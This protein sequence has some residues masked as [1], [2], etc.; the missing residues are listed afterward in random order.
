M[1]LQEA[2]ISKLQELAKKKGKLLLIEESTVSL[3]NKSLLV[4][5]KNFKQFSEFSDN[6]PDGCIAILRDVPVTKFTKNLNGRIYPKKLWEKVYNEGTAENTLSLADHP[7]DDGSITRI[8]G[9]WKNFR[10]RAEDAVADWYLIGKWGDI[11]LSVLK[12]GGKIGTS[13]VGFGEL[14]SDEATV[15]W[16]TYELVRLG[17]AVLEPSQGV[18]ATSKNLGIEPHEEL[19]N[20]DLYESTKKPILSSI[21]G[22]LSTN[23]IDRGVSKMDKAQ[24]LHLI[25]TV[26]LR[27]NEACKKQSL[28]EKNRELQD[29]LADVPENLTEIRSRIQKE[30]DSTNL[31][32]SE[33]FTASK[34]KAETASAQ[35]AILKEKFEI[36]SSALDVIKSRYQEVKNRINIYSQ[37]EK[38]MK[39]DI[40]Q[41][42][43]D[44]KLMEA[45]LKKLL[46]LYK[47][48]KRKISLF[49]ENSRL[50][51]KDIKNLLEERKTMLIDIRTLLKERKMMRKDIKQLLR[52]RKVMLTDIKAL[53]EDNKTLKKDVKK[54]YEMY[55]KTIRTNKL[56]S[57]KLASIKRKRK[58]KSS[59]T[60]EEDDFSV[61]ETTDDVGLGDET[62]GDEL[63]FD[64]GDEITSMQKNSDEFDTDELD[65]I[66]MPSAKDVMEEDEEDELNLDEDDLDS[67]D[68]NFEEE[69]DE[70]TN[71]KCECEDE[72]EDSYLS[73]AEMEYG[74]LEF[75]DE[76]DDEKNPEEDLSG[77]FEGPIGGIT[78]D[79]ALDFQAAHFAERRKKSAKRILESGKSFRG[80]SAIKQSLLKLFLTEVKKTPALK[81][82]K[83]QILNSKSLA[84]AVKKIKAFR[85]KKAERPFTM[86]ESVQSQ[87]ARASWLGH[88]F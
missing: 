45:D 40:K 51:S 19:E 68:E 13:S 35:L 1:R 20:Y 28:I 41:L 53:V 27:F 8:C 74:E 31:A 37:N 77:S 63:D 79:P 81:A 24:E 64:S 14:D 2:K 82:V 48:Q 56:L 86:T 88:R 58:R 39:K 7:E 11:I 15:I 75:Q 67:E 42:L 18:Y 57:E 54:L 83:T 33:G 30:I 5:R 25:N 66:A 29:I 60:E 34:K 36:A 6:V 21:F 22:N 17:D 23:K 65:A 12:L 46:S 76:F 72:D 70:E 52:D 32:L 78:S 50:K 55:K 69:D 62:E 80:N 4:E 38:L 85:S 10:V 49:S 3:S 71:K 9:L 87:S 47:E 26:K 61:V 44:R 73:E 59:F 43:K 84:E 16:D